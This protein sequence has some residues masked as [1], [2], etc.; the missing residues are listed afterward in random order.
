M[1]AAQYKVTAAAAVVAVGGTER[2]LYRGATVPAGVSAADIKR[3]MKMGLISKVVVA[4]P[5]AAK[6]S[7]PASEPQE[8]DGDTGSDK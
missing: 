2:Y 3:L 7:K 5:A 1:A 6:D 4:A 8:G